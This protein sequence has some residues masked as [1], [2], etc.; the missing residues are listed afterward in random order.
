VLTRFWSFGESELGNGG[1]RATGAVSAGGKMYGEGFRVSLK[2]IQEPTEVQSRSSLALY[3]VQYHQFGEVLHLLLNH[4]LEINVVKRES[5]LPDDMCTDL[6][7]YAS[8]E[9]EDFFKL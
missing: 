1:T 6:F 7:C 8:I 9:R 3:T 5:S 2:E 4:Q